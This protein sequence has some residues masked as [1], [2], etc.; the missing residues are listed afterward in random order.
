MD[1]NQIIG[2]LMIGAIL[3]GFFYFTKPKQEDL[4]RQQRIQDSLRQEQVLQ[5]AKQDS[6]N[7]IQFVSQDT[8]P[9]IVATDTTLN[10][11][12]L[13]S[14]QLQNQYGSFAKA[15]QGEQEFLTIRNDLMKVEITTKGARV[16]SVDLTKYKTYDQK[17]LILF[18]GEDNEFEL[19]FFSEGRL[20]KTSELYFTPSVTESIVDAT[21]TAKTISL[22]ANVS[23]DKYIEYLYTLKPGSYL[24]DFDINFVNLND[25]IPKNTTYL[26][27]YW[28]EYLKHL[29]R[30]EKW[31]NQNTML[32]YKLFQS[33]VEKLNPKKNINEESISS[34]VSWIG[35]KQQF[36]AS[37]LISKEH[38]DFAKI[39]TEDISEKDSVNLKY[40]TSRITIP[41]IHSN[42]VNIP[43]AF[44]YGPNKYQI[45]KNTQVNETLD[46][47]MEKMIFLGKNI[48]GFVNKVAIIPLFNFLE[49]FIGSFGIIILIMTILIKLILF[50]L[51]YKSY[52]SSAKMR[53][54]KPEIDKVTEKFTKKEDAMKKQ[55]ATM[56]LYKKAGVNPM[57][58]CLPMLFQF[59]FLVAL[60]RFFPTSIELRQQSFLWVHDLST[61][62]AVVSWTAN[63]PVVNF[64]FG[65]HISLFTMLMAVAMV[66]NTVL[67]NSN[68]DQSNPQAK[69]MK[70]MMYLMP[71]MMIVW[72]NNYS[73]G[74]SYYYFLST[75]IGIFQILF[76]RKMIDEDKVLAKLRENI[77][78]N[79]G[80]KKSKFQQRLEEMQKQQNATKNK[81][82]K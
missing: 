66:I 15:A 60:F 74:L 65:N 43:L 46:L 44:Y 62:D 8:I 48:I 18:D 69:S 19:Q 63:I 23:E 72:F 6:L 71:V 14:I 76:I 36:F 16:Y 7:N 1:R 50:P 82:K 59:P 61:Y 39:S 32:Y 37:V 45:L 24:V 4:D 38:F 20:I 21:S 75:V 31:E 28:N 49:K 81:G 53:I 47:D 68:M 64:I 33:S 26:E 58:G 51:T 22:R 54:L 52:A 17:D 5:Q 40:M 70:Y 11:D 12:S 56:D 57:G 27:L 25:L 13:V 2:F 78:N 35:Y 67:T 29:E 80:P 42:N 34:K 3:L 9:Q 73:A 77:K 10:K 55:Q 41:F 79:K 30:G